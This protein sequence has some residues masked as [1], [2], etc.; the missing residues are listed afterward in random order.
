[1]MVAIIITSSFVMVA[2]GYIP[3]NGLLEDIPYPP[4]ST[5]ITTD[6][7]LDICSPYTKYLIDRIPHKNDI[8][9]KWYETNLTSF[10]AMSYISDWLSSEGYDCVKVGCYFMNKQMSTADTAYHQGW[11]CVEYYGFLK[12]F[13]AAGIIIFNNVEGRTLILFTNGYVGYYQ[14]IMR[15]FNTMNQSL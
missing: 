7:L 2:N 1:M 10:Q 12:G 3:I 6:E 5:E 15:W 14:D 8:L 11:I 9:T 4:D 13:L